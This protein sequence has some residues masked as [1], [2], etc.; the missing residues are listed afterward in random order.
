MNS[1]TNQ[2]I[3]G[4]ILAGGRGRRMGGV[5][6]A[7]ITLANRPFLAHVIARLVPQ[8]SR[9]WISGHDNQA[10]LQ[11][12]SEGWSIVT[13][14]RAGHLGPLAGIEAG[15]MATGAAW[16]LT[17]AVDMPLL[18]VDLACRL[19][20]S[21]QRTGLPVIA[22]WQG[23]LHPTVALWPTALRSWVSQE[24]DQHHLALGRC[25][26]SISHRV[27]DFYHEKDQHDPFVNLNTMEDMVQVA[28]LFGL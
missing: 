7:L 18:P 22:A 14:R 12:W 5:D 11:P 6:K 1:D 24:L 15:M 17:V 8:V 28:P 27:V 3:D 16:L 23:H 4:L 20:P 21:A 9:I 10:Q 25:L 13:D 2:V 26:T 19:Y